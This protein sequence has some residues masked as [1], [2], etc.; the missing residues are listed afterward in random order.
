MGEPKDVVDGKEKGNVTKTDDSKSE[1]VKKYDIEK[2][3]IDEDLKSG[4]EPAEPDAIVKKYGEEAQGS[5]VRLSKIWKV[6][7]TI[8]KSAKIAGTGNIAREDVKPDTVPMKDV[9]E[10]KAHEPMEGPGKPGTWELLRRAGLRPLPG[11]R[12]TGP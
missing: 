7:P 10:T 9:K 3:K 1:T 2:G 12:N 11:A 6:R 8:Q 5:I 4:D